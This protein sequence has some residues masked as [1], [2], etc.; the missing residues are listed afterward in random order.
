[1]YHACLLL[2][3]ILMKVWGS[4]QNMNFFSSSND[5]SFDEIEP[6]L[7]DALFA[8]EAE[9][10]INGSPLVNDDLLNN[11][12]SL[13]TEPFS[14]N[15]L[16]ANDDPNCLFSS[17]SRRIRARSDSCSANPEKYLV[18]RTAEDVKKYWCSESD[19]L[20]FANI[21][22]CNLLPTAGVKP[23]EV[24]PW[25]EID[26]SSIP[27]GFISLAYCRISKLVRV[28][29]IVEL[30]TLLKTRLPEED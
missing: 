23:S 17:L 12:G 10:D 28:C 25:P 22:V 21:P 15:F 2:V 16:A 3:L 24:G 11:E 18:V 29:S 1:M 4:C 9:L 13:P 20:G 5:I 27:V 19:M 7:S 14:D 26:I 6:D 8:N 30:T